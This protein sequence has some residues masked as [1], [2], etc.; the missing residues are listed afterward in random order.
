MSMTIDSERFVRLVGSIRESLALLGELRDCP[1]SDFLADRHKQSSAKYNFIAAIEAVIDIANHVIS[2]NKLRPPTDYAD[3]FQVLAEA[4]I[5]DAPF[6]DELGQMAR[7]RNR[8]VHLY[9]DIDTEQIHQILVT[10]LGAFE[11][12]IGAVSALVAK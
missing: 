11:R 6:A 4:G 5:I 12:Y 2:R 3:A 10:R 8:L 7:F 9:W 1:K